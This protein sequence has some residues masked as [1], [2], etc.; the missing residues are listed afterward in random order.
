VASGAWIATDAALS[1]YTP[2][3]TGPPVREALQGHEGVPDRCGQ[4]AQGRRSDDRANDFALAAA[5]GLE[6]MGHG[7]RVKAL[8][9]RERGTRHIRSSR[10]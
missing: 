2:V 1:V 4:L 8:L 10:L 5:D 9:D 6:K 3:S 7:D